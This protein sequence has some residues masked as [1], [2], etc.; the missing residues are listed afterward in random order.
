LPAP[1][2]FLDANDRQIWLLSADAE[3]KRQIT[4][5]QSPI[6]GFAAAGTTLVYL[7]E[8]N[9]ENRTVVLLGP[10]G[11]RELF[12]G[13]VLRVEMTPDASEIFFSLTTPI[14]GLATNQENVPSGIYRQLTTGGQPSLLVEDGELEF[15]LDSLSPDG[16][17][18]IAS[19]LNDSVNTWQLALFDLN[20]ANRFITLDPVICCDATWSA[21]GA[22]LAIG[23]TTLNRGDSTR[24]AGLWL[25]DAYNLRSTAIIES[26]LRSDPHPDSV[27]Q[28]KAPYLLEDGSIAVFSALADH[29]SGINSLYTFDR[30][31]ADGTR[32]ET[33]EETFPM[34]SALWSPDGRGAVMIRYE[35]IDAAE[36]LAVQPLLWL[37]NDGAT[38]RDLGSSGVVL[39]WQLQSSGDSAAACANFALLSMPAETERRFDPAVADLQARLLAL[40]YNEVGEAAGFFGEQTRAALAAFQR[41]NNLKTS[42]SLDCAS[43]QQL[44][45]G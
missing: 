44:Y 17:R 4:F 38:Q 34:L 32:V 12:T 27:G 26:V 28:F 31:S 14:E 20:Q 1:L 10:G 15:I 16:T 13:P 3:S 40:G 22:Q 7:L 18:L 33:S 5:E 36:P 2:Y 25:A 37:S 45:I 39:A 24:Y 9:A 35:P 19:A 29:S 6:H 8:V 30:F 11:R 43:W 42:G 23:S 41:D 21:D